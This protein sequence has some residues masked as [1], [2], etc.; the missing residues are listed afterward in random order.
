ML[1]YESQE[2][3][4]IDLEQNFKTSILYQFDRYNC[5]FAGNSF[6]TNVLILM[7]VSVV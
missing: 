4:S 2:E 5:K 3:T 6:P 1:D 7:L